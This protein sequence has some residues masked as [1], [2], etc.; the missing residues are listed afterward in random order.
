[1]GLS[2]L[3]SLTVVGVQTRSSIKLGDIDVRVRSSREEVTQS[4]RGGSAIDTN[5]VSSSSSRL[6]WLH[7]L[8]SVDTAKTSMPDWQQT[9]RPRVR[10]KCMEERKVDE[11]DGSVA[12]LGS[13][14]G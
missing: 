9:G 13:A 4:V 10:I 3:L 12:R 6:M 11:V 14:H 5:V 7:R 2:L 8:F 1:M